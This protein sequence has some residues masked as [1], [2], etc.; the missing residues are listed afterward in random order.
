MSNHSKK[1]LGAEG[2]GD[3]EAA[4]DKSVGHASAGKVAQVIQPRLYSHVMLA[5]RDQRAAA[6]GGQSRA[7]SK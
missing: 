2:A 5:C 4:K 6:A 1:H 7:V 3:I